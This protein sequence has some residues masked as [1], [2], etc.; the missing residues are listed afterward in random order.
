[1]L[2]TWSFLADAI[3]IN[4]LLCFLLLMCFCWFANA[5]CH[6]LPS[7]YV[8]QFF[9]AM[10]VSDIWAIAFCAFN[11]FVSYSTLLHN[12]TIA[13]IYAP[14]F[15]RLGA[16]ISALL[17]NQLF[18]W[19]TLLL[20]RLRNNA[21]NRFLWLVGDSRTVACSRNADF[22]IFRREAAF[23]GVGHQVALHGPQF[24]RHNE[25]SVF[26]WRVGLEP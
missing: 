21:W 4:V 10:L 18:Y 7:S 24:H 22:G 17:L 25:L 1:M 8:K 9:I 12:C 16:Q 26:L 11:K 23:P 3:E 15:C 19:F 20:V 5:N 2:W 13:P 6:R 14:D